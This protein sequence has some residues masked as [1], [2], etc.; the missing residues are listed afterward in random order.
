M[1]TPPKVEKNFL[2]SHTSMVAASGFCGLQHTLLVLF[3]KFENT[4]AMTF[5]S[6]KICATLVH[7]DF[8]IA[9]GAGR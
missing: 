3:V 5:C 8:L 4:L 9:A 7:L 2:Q 1:A 6:S